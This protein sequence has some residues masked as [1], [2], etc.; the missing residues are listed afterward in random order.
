MK[1][2]ILIALIAISFIL[3]ISCKKKD[4]IVDKP[5]PILTGTVTDID[6]NTYK[7]VKIGDQW[8]MAENLKTSRYLNGDSIP[9]II[10]SIQW[11]NMTTGAYCNYAN[12]VDMGEKYGHLYNWY[13][14]N[15]SRDIS[16]DGW[17]IPSNE[18]WTALLMNCDNVGFFDA[19]EGVDLGSLNKKGFNILL[20]GNRWFHGTFE[21]LNYRAVW[22]SSSEW[23]ANHGSITIGGGTY[24][25]VNDTFDP[26]SYGHSIR[27]V[28]D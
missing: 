22:W 18:E 20:C 1:A 15:D 24:N 26:K 23:D 25:F 5:I 16:P 14:V 19:G 4:E 9:N 2:L 13:S 7:T 11:M 3:E 6:S 17:H 12:S 8:W 28:K 21:G 27:C 10:D